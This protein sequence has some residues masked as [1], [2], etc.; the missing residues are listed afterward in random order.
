MTRK[1]ATAA[2]HAKDEMIL[3]VGQVEGLRRVPGAGRGQKRKSP[4]EFIKRAFLACFW[5]NYLT[6]ANEL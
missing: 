4:F 1:L 6:S 3:A 2:G 5:I